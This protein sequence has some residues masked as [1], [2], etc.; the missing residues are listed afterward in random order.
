MGYLAIQ[1]HDSLLRSGEQIRSRTIR[2]QDLD[3]RPGARPEDP[4]LGSWKGVTSDYSEG[5]YAQVD[6]DDGR[7]LARLPDDPRHRERALATLRGT[8]AGAGLELSGDGWT[9]R[10]QDGIFSGQ[11]RQ[12][13]VRPIGQGRGPSSDPGHQISPSSS[14]CGSAARGRPASESALAAMI[15][16]DTVASNASASVAAADVVSGGNSG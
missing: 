2:I 8:V 13:A 4:L 12:R 5:I 9:G 7:C 6:G 16:A 14:R 11:G 15:R 3:R 1:L 10:I